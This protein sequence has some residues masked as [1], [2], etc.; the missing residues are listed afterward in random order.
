MTDKPLTYNACCICGSQPQKEFDLMNLGPL[1]F[2]EPDDGWIIGTLCNYCYREYG[3][4]QPD[5][6]DYAYT[7]TNT[8]CDKIA[9]DSDPTIALQ[10]WSK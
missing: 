2:W 6:S 4:I 7:E 8:V 10:Q 1:R 9:T 3:N 5:S